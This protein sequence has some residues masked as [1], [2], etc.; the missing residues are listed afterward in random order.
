MRLLFNGFCDES[1]AVQN[2][3]ESESVDEPF[4]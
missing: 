2:I 3:A 1:S 4:E